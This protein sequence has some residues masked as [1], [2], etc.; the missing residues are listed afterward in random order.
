MSGR[1]GHVLAG[2]VASL[3]GFC[4]LAVVVT[5]NHFA[6]LDHLARAAVHEPD[7]PS[8]LRST[9][10]G[11]SFLGGR[12]GQI[13]VICLGVAL[14]WRDR[15]RCAFALPIVMAGAGLIQHV[16]KWAVDRPR[17]N[18]DPWGFPSG[19]VLTVVVLLGFLVWVAGTSRAR[20]RAGLALWAVAVGIVA[21]SRMYLDAHWLSDVL[22]GFT[23]GLAYLLSVVWIM[24][25]TGDRSPSPATVR[26]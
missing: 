6:A 25:T 11:A 12:Y 3:L 7:S 14:C 24:S 13:A 22:G 8:V 2:A 19:H 9:M 21:F 15:R 17:P 16:A 4:V 1:S 5:G 18:L 23:V 26:T 20:R 10:E